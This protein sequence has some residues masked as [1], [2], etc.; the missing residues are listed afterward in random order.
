MI[1]SLTVLMA[2]FVVS[3]V[4]CARLARPESRWFVAD[5]AN[6]RSMHTGV[7][8]RNGGLGVLL[9]VVVGLI[10]TVAVRGPDLGLVLLAGVP[11]L[12]LLSAADDRRSLPA[13][14]R[15]AVHLLIA[16]AMAAWILV[17]GATGWFW[18]PLFTLGIA[19]CINLFN[20]MDG[21]D[22]LAGSQATVGFAGL[23]LLGVL[24]GAAEPAIWPALVAAAAAGFLTRNWPKASIFLGDVGSTVFGLLAGVLGLAGVVDGRWPFWAPLVLFA[25]FWLD[26]TWTLFARWRRGARLSEAH[27]EH[28][29]Q[30]LALAGMPHRRVLMFYLTAMFWGLA[31]VLADRLAALPPVAAPLIWALGMAIGIAVVGR[32]AAPRPDGPTPR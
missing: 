21:L 3:A 22:G 26:A 7:T 32:S 4:A 11:P 5:Q 30:R 23:A 15:L 29:Y 17:T 14:L 28:L 6:A 2:A 13:R 20:F 1:A 18:W 8:P 25:P 10:A 31:A 19:W 27:R 12:A 24:S 9:G 16:G